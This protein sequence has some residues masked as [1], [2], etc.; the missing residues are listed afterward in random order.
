M[1]LPSDSDAPDRRPA[2]CIVQ[3][4]IG[5]LTE[6]FIDAHYRHLRPPVIRLACDPFPVHTENGRPLIFFLHPAFHRLPPKLFGI[7]AHRADAALARRLPNAV[8]C[9][10]LARHLRR[11]SV[12]VVLAEYGPTGVTMR[13]VCR[14]A[15]AP[16][17]VHFH[18]YDAYMADVVERH[19]AGYATLFRDAAAIVAVSRHM[20]SRLI[21]LG[22]PPEKVVLNPY[23]I[24]VDRF[25]GA[26]PE[27]NPPIFLAV[28]RL[29]EKKA[30]QVTI[31]SF[32]RVHAEHPSSRLLMVG[33]GPL[34]DQCS[35]LVADLGIVNSVT[36]AGP[37]PHH[38]VAELMTRV[39]CFVQHSVRPASGDMEGTPLAVLEAMASGLPVVATRHGG[40][41]DVVVDGETGFPVDE[42]DVSGM[43]ATM[44]TLAADRHRAADLGAAGRTLVAREHSIV[45]RIGRLADLLE[46]VIADSAR[47]EES[48]SRP[49]RPEPAP[50]RSR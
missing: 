15:G 36:L 17:V 16:L 40:I 11:R 20:R 47:G 28:G 38:E 21:D 25:S 24:D 49:D 35:K 18:G 33:D 44:S 32:A 23:G 31:Q 3:P 50:R 46:R 12:G 8:R 30:P 26:R 9:S 7:A 10:A 37:R 6:T 45:D 42:G 43:A 2:I 39:R 4:K 41:V 29:V 1:A 27:R 22:A 34:A 14:A 19:R 13:P 48:R 5:V